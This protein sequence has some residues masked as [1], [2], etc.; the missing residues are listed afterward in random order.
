MV[1]TA[2]S[3]TSIASIMQDATGIPIQP[4]GACR[5]CPAVAADLGPGQVERSTQGF[6]KRRLRENRDCPHHAVDFE[7]QRHRV[8][9]DRRGL[10]LRNCRRYGKTG[11]EH[12]T[13]R[14]RTGADKKRS[15]RNLVVIVT[16][17]SRLF[18]S[19]SRFAPCPP[20]P[21]TGCTVHVRQGQLNG[22]HSLMD[23]DDAGH[24]SPGKYRYSGHMT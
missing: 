3:P 20:N 4:H 13:S 16:Y 22:G 5:A 11:F 2:R 18:H 17:G 9:T 15:A 21:T 19:R 24:R 7:R 8:G 12:D 6:G 10:R 1:V 23:I 14:R